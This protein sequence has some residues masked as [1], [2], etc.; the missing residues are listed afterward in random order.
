M[1]ADFR[2]FREEDC[3]R[4][5]LCFE[6]CPVLELPRSKA[7]NDIQHL[8]AG[9]VERSLA[10]H[11]CTTCNVC[12]FLCPEGALPYEL[13]LERFDESRRTHGLPP[14]AKLIFPD[15]PENIWTGLRPLMDRDERVLLE[16]WEQ[17]LDTQMEEIILTGFYTNIVPFLARLTILDDLRGIM[18]GAE[19]LC[20]CGGDSNK[21]GMIE[22]T[23]D[24]IT[25]LKNTFSRMGVRQV[26]CFMEAEAMMLGEVLPKRYGAAFDV[27]ALPLDY[28]I[29]ERIRKRIISL[30]APLDMVVTVHDNCMSRYDGG[31]PQET[32]RS[33]LQ[34]TGCT[35]REMEH[36]GF[37]GLC[38]GWAATIPTL[39]G[40]GSGNPMN[41]LLSL[42]S[43][44]YRRLEEAQRTGADAI[45][46]SCPACYIFLNLIAALTMSGMKVYHVL[47]VV[48]LATGNT[49]P[50]KIEERCWEVLAV[51]T[52]LLTRWMGSSQDRRRF[53]P[54]PIDTGSPAPLAGQHPEDARRTGHLAAFFKHRLVQNRLTRKIVKWAVLGGIRG[55]RY[56]ERQEMKRRRSA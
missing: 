6:G 46:T 39:H 19:G 28:L 1:K 53:H 40:R 42:L 37:N 31:R 27:T 23:E 8:I 36:T 3:T 5:G 18:A 47:E 43:S 16:E 17:R 9:S 41:T 54:K 49:P 38:C 10:F 50:R 25:L 24:I 15:E 30:T 20:G 52:T 48:E 12:D 29:L 26:Y 32:I 22:Q 14:I 51:A 56:R 35:I 21:L 2:W 55:Y 11:R 34:L 7:V 4:C 44:L 33:I 13:I 45:V